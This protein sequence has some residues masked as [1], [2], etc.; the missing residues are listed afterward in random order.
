MLG[1]MVRNGTFQDIQTIIVMAREF[2]A[3]TGYEDVYDSA[4]VGKMARTCINYGLMSV[5]E[6]EGRVC[7]FACGLPSQLLANHSVMT[8]TEVA[9]WVNPENRSGRNGISLLRHLEKQAKEKGIKYWNMIFMES[10]M[11]EQV[12]KIYQSLGYTKAEV[13]YTRKL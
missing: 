13:T 9:W 7:G 10:S 1:S 8:G 4:S 12:E 2:W 3:H 5:L 11:P 6:I